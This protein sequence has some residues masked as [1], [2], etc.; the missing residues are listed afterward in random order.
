MNKLNN[1]YSKYSELANPF[2]QPQIKLRTITKDNKDRP[3][4][5]TASVVYSSSTG[6]QKI[7]KGSSQQHLL[8]NDSHFNEEEN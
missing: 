6:S 5:L 2:S 3:V 7:L 1:E 4:T 8:E